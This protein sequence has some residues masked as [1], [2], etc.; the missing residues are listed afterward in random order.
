MWAVGTVIRMSAAP[1]AA[2]R[3]ALALMAQCI[4]AATH[5]SAVTT[6]NA[7]LL[8][9]VSEPSSTAS[10][11]SRE[12]TTTVGNRL[13][14]LSCKALAPATMA[15]APALTAAAGEI[16]QPETTMTTTTPARLRATAPASYNVSRR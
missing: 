14:G 2:T 5:H 9:S 12:T 3:P 6:T 4:P 11:I 15:A 13:R 16:I 8:P 7:M 10:A 1:A